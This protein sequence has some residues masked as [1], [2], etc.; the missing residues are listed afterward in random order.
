M[1]HGWIDTNEYIDLWECA[2]HNEHKKRTAKED[3]HVLRMS[4]H[5]ERMGMDKRGMNS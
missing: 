1:D 3:T 4:G 2:N 5:R